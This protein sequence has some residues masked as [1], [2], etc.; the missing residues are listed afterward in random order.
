VLFSANRVFWGLQGRRTLRFLPSSTD[1]QFRFQGLLA[2][3]YFMSAVS[4]I[5]PSD[6][7][8]PTF[9]EQLVNAS[10]KL[11]LAE[12]EKKVQDLKLAR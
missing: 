3:D 2:G 5:D 6:F 12:G 8:D 7:G 4:D 11:T 10:I 1:G 9:F